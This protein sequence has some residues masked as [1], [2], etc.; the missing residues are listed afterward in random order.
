[1]VT[2][3][4]P[5]EDAGLASLDSEHTTRR[6]RTISQHTN[7]LDARLMICLFSSPADDRVPRLSCTGSV[8]VFWRVS[9]P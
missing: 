8:A 1:M 7:A 9:T 3:P 5:D 4:S 2:L 6:E